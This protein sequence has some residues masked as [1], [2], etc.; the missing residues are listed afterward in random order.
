MKANKNPFVVLFSI[1][2]VIALLYGAWQFYANRKAEENSRQM[3]AAPAPSGLPDIFHNAP[4]PKQ[5]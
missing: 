2:G 5:P 3:F 1:I 4:P